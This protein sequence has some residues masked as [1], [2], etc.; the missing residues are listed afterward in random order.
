MQR[1]AKVGRSGGKRGGGRRGG[2]RGG[3]GSFG[4]GGLRGFFGG[5]G[6]SG[7]G[8]TF[9]RSG[10]GGGGGG[11]SGR[12][13]SGWRSAWWNRDPW[14]EPLES[15]DGGY[16]RGSQWPPRTGEQWLATIVAVLFLIALVGIFVSTR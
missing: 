6:R 8:G 10:S 14:R 9:G 16:E 3:G 2:R 1:M 5:G 12:S 15:D 7:G 4:R 11:R 13:S